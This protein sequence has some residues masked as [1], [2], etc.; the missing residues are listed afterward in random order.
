MDGGP[1]PR[2]SRVAAT[3]L[4][5]AA[6]LPRLYGDP[7]YVCFYPASPARATTLPTYKEGMK[8]TSGS[9]ARITHIRRFNP[10][11][12]AGPTLPGCLR[13]RSL[14]SPFQSNG[15]CGADT[16]WIRT[17]NGWVQTKFQSNG[18]CGADTTLPV[19]TC[20]RTRSKFQ[21]NGLCGADTTAALYVVGAQYP[22]SGL[23]RSSPICCASA[24]SGGLVSR[25]TSEREPA[26]CASIAGGSR[27]LHI[28]KT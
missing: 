13:Y 16:T 19:C 10:T 8:I 5:V 15:L 7:T 18:L 14:A 26:G 4:E 3:I 23:P 11:A 22:N 25:A 24:C 21:S 2:P 27:C 6:P 17:D 20:V 9:Q 28:R 1:Q 12:F